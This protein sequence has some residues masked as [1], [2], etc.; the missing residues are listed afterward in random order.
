LTALPEPSRTGSV[1]QSNTFDQHRNSLP[2][3]DAHRHHGALKLMRLEA[4][5]SRH[6]EA[7]A[8][9]PERMAKRDG[10]AEGVIDPAILILNGQ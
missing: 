3:A 6:R 4:I 1:T 7:G 8:G 5:D 9:H 10:A 2:D